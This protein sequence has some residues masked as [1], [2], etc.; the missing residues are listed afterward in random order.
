M[1][2]SKLLVRV[3]E[4][5]RVNG[6]K[7]NAYGFAKHGASQLKVWMDGKASGLSSEDRLKTQALLGKTI[8]RLLNDKA[9]AIDFYEAAVKELAPSDWKFESVEKLEELWDRVSSK[10]EAL[11]KEAA[12]A[13]D[14]LI[15]LQRQERIIGERL[16]AAAE[17][18][19]RRAQ[20]AGN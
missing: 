8:E 11:S 13:F 3:S 10:D 12:H 14:R 18:R 7:A 17:V 16:A 1:D 2:L 4:T 19:H 20:A 9:Q 6:D 5:A 15:F